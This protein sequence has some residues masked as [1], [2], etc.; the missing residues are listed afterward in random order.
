MAPRS[1]LGPETFTIHLGAVGILK[2][3]ANLLLHRKRTRLSFAAIHTAQGKL[4][5]N[6]YSRP[7]PMWVH[8]WARE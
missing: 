8:V 5:N 1:C 3:F 4:R 7:K 2:K 6:V